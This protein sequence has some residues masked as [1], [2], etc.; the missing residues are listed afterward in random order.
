MET[1]RGRAVL[2]QWIPLSIFRDRIGYGGITTLIGETDPGAA[3]EPEAALP[4]VPAEVRAGGYG[5][6]LLNNILTDIG[7]KHVSVVRI[8]GKTLGIPN[9]EGVNLAKG[10]A[11]TVIGEWIISRNAV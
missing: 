7:K 11:V 9:T 1:G 10:I 4:S 2:K 3:N 6:Y 5:T 8:P